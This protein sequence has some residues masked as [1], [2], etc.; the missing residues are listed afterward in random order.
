MFPN[1]DWRATSWKRDNQL[2]CNPANIVFRRIHNLNIE[3]NIRVNV[4]F[5]I[6]LA[7]WS[8]M[9]TYPAYKTILSLNTYNFL[10]YFLSLAWK[11]EKGN[12]SPSSEKSLRNLNGG[13]CGAMFFGGNC[14]SLWKFDGNKYQSPTPHSMFRC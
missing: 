8:Q 12:T 13:R 6:K 3:I 1:W 5:I 7:K 14:F 11:H 2:S 4:R 10:A 9:P